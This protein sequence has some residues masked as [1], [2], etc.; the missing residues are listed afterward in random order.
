MHPFYQKPEWQQ[1]LIAIFLFLLGVGFLILW[2]VLILSSF[3]WYLSAFFLVPIFQ[4]T[5]SPFFTKIGV[6]KYLS[7]ML[8]VFGATEK[9]YGI[10]NGTSFD[11]LF[12]MKGIKPGVAWRK[13]LLL[14]YI[15]GLLEIVKKV[16]SGELPKE[17]KVW[18]SSYFFSQ[19]TAERLGFNIS[20]T[21]GAEKLNIIFNYLDLLWMYSLSKGKLTFPQLNGIKT[22]T[23]T[24][25]TLLTQK[26]KLEKLH[27]RLQ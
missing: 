14:Y 27:K 24:G 4:F 10:H 15:E 11:Y 21:G 26:S 13:R 12:T 19:S 3:L 25:E 6:F 5:F 23:T 8:L 9:N 1:W 7:P 2:T 22:A 17:V 20:D 18:G 16:E